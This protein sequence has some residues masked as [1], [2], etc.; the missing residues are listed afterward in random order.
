MQRMKV[1]LLLGA[2]VLMSANATH[3]FA[4]TG[5]SGKVTSAK[6]GAMEGVLVTAK[7]DGA[8]MSF[9]VVSDEKGQYSFPAGRLEPG[10]YSL[11][12]RAIG[13]VL[14]GPKAV[15]VTAN[16]TTADVKLNDTANIAPQMTNSEWLVSAPGT[17][18]QKRDLVAC[19][20]CHTLAR[21]MMS[22]YT[23][24]EFKTDVFA[25]MA[26]FSSQAFPVL[27]QK[28][29]VQR[30]QART[31]G[32]LDRLAE[33]IS[34]INLS[35]APEHKFAL[36]A[37][38]RPRGKDTKV[39]ITSY[40]LPRKS[41]QP[42][43]AV[44]GD[45]GFVWV[46]DFGEN[47]LSKLDPKTGKV[48]E[49]TY[50]QTRPGDYSNG[51]LDLEFD[52]QG[53]IWIGMMNQTGAAKFDRKTEKFTFYPVPKEMLDDETQTAM[54][55]PVNS[56]VDGKAWINSA[57]KP[58]VSRFDIKTGKFEGWKSPFKDR[59]KGEN[60]SAYGVYTDSHNNAYLMDFPSQYV[61][62]IDAKSG[63]VTSYKTP[64][65]YSRPRRGRMDNQDRLW[66]AEWRADKI[67]MFDTK[68]GEFMEWKV[69]GQYVAPYDAQIDKNGEVW[70]DNMMDDRVTRIDPRT[71]KAVQFLMPIETNSRRIA[72]DDYGARPGIWIGANHQAIVMKVEPLE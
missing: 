16:G 45:D 5:L 51:N 70:T 46:T 49:Y 57:E 72:V 20:T 15:D 41:M 14:N 29:I 4:A 3:A 24:D 32:G 23:K 40:D 21:P 22:A 67:A 6:E 55:A 65:D 1:S 47:S 11:K 42:H 66:F 34:T 48:V 54:V 35:T 68:S 50:P 8:N 61:W 36:K 2:A 30:D 53:N 38:P 59:P 43:D 25:R 52:K 71:G 19:A 9:T 62:K 33:Y 10:H 64:S 27:V 17:E 56:H 31:F 18:D 39:L 69:P 37:F 7:K 58:V 13:Y 60:H 28:R 63:A 12:I 26:D 44:M